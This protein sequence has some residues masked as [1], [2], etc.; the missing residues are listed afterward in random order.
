MYYS[1]FDL[2]AGEYLKVGKNSKT[3]NDCISDVWDYISKK[4][5]NEFEDNIDEI[6]YEIEVSG[7][8]IKE[9]ESH[10]YVDN[11]IEIREHK[12]KINRK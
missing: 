5:D 9:K 8:S 2:S 4:S 3:K 12:N 1:A 10:L 11:L 6:S 7:Y